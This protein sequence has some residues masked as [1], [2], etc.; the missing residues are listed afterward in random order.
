MTLC[1]EEQTRLFRECAYVMTLGVLKHFTDLLGDVIAA[2]T[3]K[4]QSEALDQ[5]FTKVKHY[6]RL[7]TAAEQ[8]DYLQHLV[9]R[10]TSVLTSAPTCEEKPK[11][12]ETLKRHATIDFPPGLIGDK[13]ERDY[14]FQHLCVYVAVLEKALGW[15]YA[16]PSLCAE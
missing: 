2:T 12:I 13:G 8:R 10:L 4:E 14:A 7:E 1:E 11:M 16:L 9:N 5:V 6:S 15:K 3:S